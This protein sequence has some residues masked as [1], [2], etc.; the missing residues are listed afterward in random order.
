MSFMW[1]YYCQKL[2]FDRRCEWPGLHVVPHPQCA[3]CGEIGTAAT[4]KSEFVTE[5]YSG[6]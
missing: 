2:C 6:H 3:P 4:V 5:I 1:G